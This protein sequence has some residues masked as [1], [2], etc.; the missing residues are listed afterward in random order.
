MNVRDFRRITTEHIKWV[1][2]KGE[3]KTYINGDE[4]Q[5]MVTEFHVDYENKCIV[6]QVEHINFLIM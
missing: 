3:T 2:T 4:T 5:Y 1:G 6:A